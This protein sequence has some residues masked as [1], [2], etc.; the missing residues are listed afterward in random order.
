MKKI[1]LALFL[2]LG[3]LCREQS[4]A[5]NPAS[6]SPDQI[7][8]EV[9]R[10][11]FDP[12]EVEARMRARGFDPD[13]ISDAQM[14]AA[15]QAFLEIIQELEK[16]RGAQPPAVAPANPPAASQAIPENIPVQDQ[17]ERNDAPPAPIAHE[18]PA[19]IYGQ[20]LFRDRRLSI[21]RQTSELTVPDDYLLGPG[22]QLVVSIW[23]QVAAYSEDLQV[24]A[25][26]YVIPKTL[27]RVYLTGLT[28][29]QAKRQLQAVFAQRYPVDRTNFAVSLSV[30][31]TVDVNITGEVFDYGSFRL[32]ALNP[33]FNALV[34][35]G[36][37]TDIGSVRNIMLYRS[38]QPPIRLDVYQYLLD[39][40]G[41]GNIYLQNGD[42]LFVPVAQRVVG[43]E[44]AVRRPARYELIAGEQL[45]Q[46]LEWAGGLRGD[47]YTASVQVARIVNQQRI[48]LDVNLADLLARNQDFD[49]LDGDVVTIRDISAA[50][51]NFVNVEGAVEFA[52]SYAFSKD[53]KITDL[54]TRAR[55]RKEA[56]TDFA[57]LQRTRT[58]GT[59]EYLS[60]NLAA[61]LADPA[62]TAN[63]ALQPRDRLIVFA[64]SRFVDEANIQSEG[65][66]R[67]AKTL[68]FDAGRQLRVSD[69]I[70]LSGGLRPDA[71]DFAY[72]I[73]TQ[74]D[75]PEEK[76]YIRIDLSAI[77]ANPKAQDNLV[78]EPFDRL[79]VQSKTLFHDVYNV[80]VKGAVRNPGDYQ[81]DPSLQLQD[82]ISLAGGL[83]REAA[84]DRV[85]V[86]RVVINQ[87]Q[88][89]SVV[90]GTFKIDSLF[91]V[92]NNGGFQLQ[93]FDIVVVRAVPE[94]ELQKM[95]TIRGE[96]RYP[97]EYAL[98]DKNEQ[99]LSVIQRAG[100]LS[101]EAFPPG[102]TL[103]RSDGQTGF[104]V[105]R[106][107]AVLKDP[108]DRHNFVLKAGDVI[109][110][111][112]TKDLVAIRGATRAFDL[113]PDKVIGNNGSIN[114]AYR[115]GKHAGWYVREYAAGFS[116][117]A[118]RKSLTVEE[119]NGRL[120]RTKNFLLFKIYPPVSKGATINVAKKPAQEPG[121]GVAKKPVDWDA[122]LA[123]TLAKA[124]SVLTLLVLLQR[125]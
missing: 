12:A 65:A 110:I 120:R 23:G 44:G 123:E 38:G 116:D 22:D 108:S 111:P 124:T 9:A 113:Y 28:Y 15:Q 54:L 3:V 109:E 68:P 73:R 102:A 62:G 101:K 94:F 75:N 14:P 114:V 74:L 6:L 80:Q 35:T 98:I 115:A 59:S 11:G 76:S 112:K 118:S 56:R 95:V 90:V 52:G 1:L 87:N 100:G 58:D 61:A 66:V 91:R 49:L 67:E 32:S 70:A 60:I 4:W 83:R 31:R 2:L 45:R 42:N 48:F 104:V 29:G 69:L 34:A 43:I 93:P 105:L 46:L 50:A 85:D 16:A 10:R 7:R 89:T 92:L 57:Y 18:G 25:E 81:W 39:P 13:H 72:L 117:R 27:S 119:A 55:L 30:A 103:Y 8:A 79:T 33:A 86:F 51:E 19:R 125:L 122:V 40:S 97:G 26:G 63:T 82:L 53:L 64:Q 96:V 17:P 71:T 37:P 41:K 77:A 47:A 88:P 99:L 36:G 20:Q 24:N 84:S 107:D 106:L 5:Q 121:T 78:L 21:Y